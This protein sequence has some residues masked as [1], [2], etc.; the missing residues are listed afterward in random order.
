MSEFYIGGQRGWQHDEG[1]ASGIFHSYDHFSI[2]EQT[3]K[4]HLFLPRDYAHHQRRYPLLVMHDG[5]AVFW[6]GGPVHKSWRLGESL[7]A[8][9]GQVVQPIVLAIPPKDRAYEYTPVDWAA[10]TRPWGGLKAYTRYLA[11]AVIP[12]VRAHYRIQAGPAAVVGS[13]HGGL[14]AFYNATTRPDAFHQAGAMSPSVWVEVDGWQEPRPPKRLMEGKLL[15]EAAPVLMDP[16]RRPVLW[17]C[18]GLRR[19]GG[20]HNHRTEALVTA[21]GRE[22]AKFC[23][24]WGYHRQNLDATTV[25]NPQAN[26]FVYED[27]NAG[28]DEEAWHGRMGQLLRAFFPLDQGR[29]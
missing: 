18:W 14:A 4:I 12:W 19:D 15:Q 5:D 7:T 25:P 22:L 28:H 17:L 13:S 3:R 29:R 16:Q 26:L 21:R 23:E 11:D 9:M 27:P 20:F 10:G 2:A 1:L 24:Q 6:P 8:A